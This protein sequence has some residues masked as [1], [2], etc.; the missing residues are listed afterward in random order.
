LLELARLRPE[1]ARAAVAA[2]WER[3][4]EA[5]HAAGG[6]SIHGAGTIG[7]QALAAARRAGIPVRAFIDSDPQRSG[8]QVDGVEV[9]GVEQIVAGRSVVLPAVG[10]HAQSVAAIARERGAACVLE[11][12]QLYWHA[13]PPGEPEPDYL[14]DLDANRQRYQAL[15]TTVADARSREVLAALIR[16]R[17]TLELAPL[18]AVCE[19]EHAQWFAPELLPRPG[20]E[21][22]VDG[23]A[24][25]GD[26]VHGYIAACGDGY[27]AIH[28]FEL[29]PLLAARGQAR[30]RDLRA[31]RFAAIGLSDRAGRVAYRGSGGTD[32]AVTGVAQAGQASAE[33]GRLDELVREPISFL[34]LDVEGEEAR[35]L[36]GARHHLAHDRPTLALALYHKAPDIWQLPQQALAAT[37][38]YRLHLRHYTEL[39][40]ETV[41][42]AT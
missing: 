7:R 1:P 40:Y 26:T 11:L 17:R 28:A 9:Q 34:K 19:R 30:T 41:L 27:A 25:D 20:A 21:V 39:A 24:F 22:Y 15:F 14:D 6:L 23:G 18:A 13:R 42:Y 3:A 8:Q 10:R 4:L 5:I 12:S 2:R 31:V 36:T 37:P 32:S 16:Q 38:S 29:D 35:A 33:I